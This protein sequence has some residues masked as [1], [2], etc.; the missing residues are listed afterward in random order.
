MFKS[1]SKSHTK[2]YV[3]IFKHNVSFSKSISFILAVNELE[4]NIISF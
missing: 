1:C 3:V 4:E 2:K